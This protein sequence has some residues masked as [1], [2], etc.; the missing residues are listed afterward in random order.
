MLDHVT[1]HV[2]TA[3]MSARHNVVSTGDP[4]GPV[5]L[6]AHGF[7]CDQ[8]M[9]RHLVPAFTHDHRVVLFDHIGAGRSDSSGYDPVRY[10]GLD[11]YADDILGI[12]AELDLTDVTLVAHSVSA[13]MAVI[14]AVAQPERF[15]QLVL[16]A[17]SPYMLMDPVSGYDGGFS[18]EDLAD[19][20][21]TLD[22]NYFTW[23]EAMAPVIMGVPDAPEL[24]EQLTASFCRT[25]PDIAGQLIRTIFSTDCRPLLP[26][27]RTP[28]LVLQCRDDAM[29]PLGVGDHLHEHLAG[30]TL[31]RLEATGHCPHM[32]APQ[33]TA[34]A[35]RRHLRTSP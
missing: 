35:I 11:G 9:W 18:A 5:L 2:P 26:R 13:M 25:D 15:R 3:V 30:S 8:D 34:A 31:V 21:S 29:A 6:F 33:E 17:P 27:V 4:D 10:A 7:G 1:H 28:A 14:A 23:A 19:V 16:V 22:S 32:S 24:D 20:M 12:C